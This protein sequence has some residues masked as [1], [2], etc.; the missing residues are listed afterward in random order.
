MSIA[1]FAALMA[2][3]AAASVIKDDFKKPNTNHVLKSTNLVDGPRGVTP[4][5]PPK[6]ANGPSEFDAKIQEKQ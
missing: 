3:I 4:P 6:G 1:V 5:E 2:L